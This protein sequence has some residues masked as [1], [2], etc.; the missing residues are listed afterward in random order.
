MLLFIDESGTDHKSVPYEV[1]AGVSIDER[2]A[3]VFIQAIQKARI[4]DFGVQLNEALKEFKGSQLLKKKTFRLAGQLPLIPNPERQKLAFSLLEKG[5][6]ARNQGYSQP[7]TKAELTAYAQSCLEYSKCVLDLCA[8]YG[9]QVFASIVDLAAPKPVDTA[10][11]KDVTYLLE[12]FHAS[13]TPKDHGI[14]VFDELDVTQSR[15]LGSHMRAYFE[16]TRTG[17]ERAKR[18]LPEP[19]FVHSDITT[20]VQVADLV[21]YSLNWGWRL[22]GKMT[23]ATRV[24]I[25]LFAAQIAGLQ[26]K[27]KQ[28]KG[29]KIWTLRGFCFIQD[30]RSSR[31]R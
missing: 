22:E 9:V 26:F 28:Q 29:T 15:R 21:A 27:G 6:I 2:R 5:H 17:R 10:I 3:W 18:I 19:F 13:L 8:E 16:D 31:E 1:L 11:R 23:K 12:R 7:V 14:I 4:E 30:L 24:E 20:L 25:E